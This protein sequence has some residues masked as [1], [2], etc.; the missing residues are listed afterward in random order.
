M[1][2]DTD[3]PLCVIRNK[4]VASARLLS[5]HGNDNAYYEKQDIVTNIYFEAVVPSIIITN[6]I[7]S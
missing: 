7:V 3:S 4:D 1:S 6:F 2:K 5:L